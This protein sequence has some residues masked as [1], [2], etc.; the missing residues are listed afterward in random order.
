VSV[1]VSAPGCFWIAMMTAGVPLS[2]PSPRL[3]VGPA[4]DDR[5]HVV[6]HQ[7]RPRRADMVAG[8]RGDEGDSAMSSAVCTRP[9]LRTTSS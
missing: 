3:I 6:A 4:S 1:I 7:H 9:M 8:L 5:R 2:D